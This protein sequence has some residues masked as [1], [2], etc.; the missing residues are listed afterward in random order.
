MI[1]IAQISA[2]QRPGSSRA[3]AAAPANAARYE[4]VRLAPCHESSGCTDQMIESAVSAVRA[5]NNPTVV[6]PHRRAGALNRSAA[7]TA[8]APS[9][10]I[11]ISAHVPAP[12]TVID[13]ST[14]P[15]VTAASTIR[16]AA[17]QTA[18][19]ASPVGRPIPDPAPREP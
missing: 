2:R 12:E 16:A 14:P 9:S 1:A 15:V 6:A 8:A 13:S 17:R 7:A 18:I 3:S 5:A 19:T 10:V 11:A 4:S